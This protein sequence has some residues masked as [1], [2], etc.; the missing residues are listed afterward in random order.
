MEHVRTQSALT[1]DSND[2]TMYSYARQCWDVPECKALYFPSSTVNF[3]DEYDVF[4]SFLTHLIDVYMVSLDYV[5]PVNDSMMD[6]GTWLGYELVSKFPGK[7]YCS[8][9]ESRYYD[10]SKKL[11][12]CQCDDTD[13]CIA[14]SS[15]SI[16]TISIVFYCLF[17]ILLLL[18]CCGCT[19]QTGVVLC[20]I[21]KSKGDI[22]E[23]L[24]A[25]ARSGM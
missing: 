21:H 16:A 18:V 9:Y 4:V 19:T 23:L 22:K 8:M 7:T 12:E 15:N 14:Q 2:E 17:L 3:M 1:Q 11:W 24:N 13:L 5:A 10:H 25:L 6:E 20:I